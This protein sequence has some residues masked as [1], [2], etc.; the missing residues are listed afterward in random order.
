MHHSDCFTLAVTHAWDIQQ[1][2]V[3]NAFLNGDLHESVYMTQPK[4]F[5]DSNFPSHVCKLHKVIYG[6][7][8]APRVWFDRLKMSL[9]PR[10]FINSK[11]DSSLFITHK[12]GKLLLVL[13]Y[14]DD[15]LVTGSD[16]SQVHKLIADLGLEFALKSLGSVNYFLGFQLSRSKD[17]IHLNQSK[18]THDLFEKTHMLDA[19]PQDS[20]MCPSVK[21]SKESGT[22]LADPKLYKSIIGAL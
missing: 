3:N 10:G 4:G 16:K 21:L 2:N 13:V 1:I 6:L 7:H 8:Q 19:K 17:T 5:Q 15:I 22:P 18:Y 12:N 9:L 14:V 20:P 11:S